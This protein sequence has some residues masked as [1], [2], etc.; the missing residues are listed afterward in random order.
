MDGKQ[1]SESIN[2]TDTEYAS[3][4]DVVNMHRTASHET[5]FVS[6]IPNIIN[7]E[8]VTTAPGQG[9]KQF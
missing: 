1:M 8:Y 5:T 7:E 3:V 2:E 9:K 4:E 6:E